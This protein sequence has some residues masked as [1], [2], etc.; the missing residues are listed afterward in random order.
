LHF[1]DI[2]GHSPW[3]TFDYL[4]YLKPGALLSPFAVVEDLPRVGYYRDSAVLAG[5]WP[6][7][8]PS[9]SRRDFPSLEARWFSSGVGGAYQH[10]PLVLLFGGFPGQDP[11]SRIQVPMHT[12]A[13][14]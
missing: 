8:E 7:W 5:R 9:H 14:P 4:C 2:H 12:I 10:I 1:V 13:A 11:S 3:L 6:V